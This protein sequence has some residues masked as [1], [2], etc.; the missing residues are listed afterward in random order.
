M[1]RDR[2]PFPDTPLQG[3]GARPLTSAGFGRGS[4]RFV[5][6]RAGQPAGFCSMDFWV[7]MEPTSDPCFACGCTKP[8][9]SQPPSLISRCGGGCQHSEA[10]GS[11]LALSRGFSHEVSS[12]R[13]CLC[14]LDVGGSWHSV[15]HAAFPKRGRLRA[16]GGAVCLPFITQRSSRT[17]DGPTRPDRCPCRREQTQRQ[18]FPQRHGETA[19]DGEAEVGVTAGRVRS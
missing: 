17:S 1:R 10:R 14:S 5:L 9:T 11:S 4:E 16:E 19:R 6:K 18:T 12:R 7:D 2:R 8:P 13:S 15:G 3:K